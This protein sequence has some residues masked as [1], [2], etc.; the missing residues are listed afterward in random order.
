MM[1]PEEYR[2]LLPK[3]VASRS[4]ARRAGALRALA[5]LCLM[6]A[7]AAPADDRGGVDA[8][9]E[10]DLTLAR[11]AAVGSAPI[12][13]DTSAT[14]V[15][16]EE[17]VTEPV[18][19][20]LSAPAAV[21]A[22][23]PARA[24]AAVSARTPDP[25]A[26]VPT[27]L[28]ET[29]AEPTPAPVTRPTPPSADRSAEAPARGAGSDSALAPVSTGA[30]TSGSGSGDGA[31][32]GAGAGTS[33]ARRTLAAAGAAL[34][35]GLG[36]KVC[37]TTNRPGDRVVMRLA[38][39]VVGP[40]GLALAAGTP[41]LLQLV[42]TADSALSFRVLSISYNGE[43]YPV[44]A[45]VEVESEM[46]GARVAGGSDKKSVIGGALAGAILGRVLGGGTK[47]TV[48]GAAGG[49]A[50]GAAMAR[51][52][53]ITEQCLPAGALVTV[54]LTEPVYLNGAGS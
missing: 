50:A 1:S 26:A 38:N 34:A 44:V 18:A 23:T 13:G 15:T 9:L 8:S 36:S 16:P 32:A 53:S 41:V 47:G 39:A 7:C 22:R 21:S 28:P 14:D 35:G 29:V 6:A 54:R 52:N 17:L 42:A 51:R 25:V 12:F 3:P 48:V 33:G 20:A 45:S 19:K 30:S 37:N 11:P 5:T 40:D 49:A 2:P 27:R 31:A 10:R 46:E 4:L 24:A 43:L